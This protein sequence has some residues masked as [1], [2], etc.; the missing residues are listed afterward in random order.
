MA[1]C[2]GQL[3]IGNIDWQEEEKR[4]NGFK[5]YWILI[6]SINSCTS[7]QFKDI[8]E[9][10]SLILHCKTMY[11]YQMTLPS[12]STTS[13]TLSKCT[14]LSNVVWS[15][16]EKASEGTGSQCSSQPWTGC[17]KRSGR[18]PIRSGQTQN[19]SVQKYVQFEA[20]SMKGVAIL[21]N[22]ITCNYSFK[23][24]TSD[25]YRTSGMY[26]S[27][28]RITFH[29]KYKQLFFLFWEVNFLMQLQFLAPVELFF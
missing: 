14:P 18:S 2:N 24:T 16:E 5:I 10:F 3:M 22:S 9:V 11:G 4:T 8:Q 1:L 20:C 26:E 29:R 15:H 28:W 13:E 17:W 25:L 6:R 19:L 27:W 12:T 23:H 7:R 21:S